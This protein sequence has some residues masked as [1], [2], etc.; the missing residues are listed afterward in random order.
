MLGKKSLILY[1]FCICFSVSGVIRVKLNGI[2]YFAHTL[3]YLL[4]GS[5]IRFHFTER[6]GIKIDYIRS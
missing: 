4:A 6:D 2:V 3:T 1:G 5:L